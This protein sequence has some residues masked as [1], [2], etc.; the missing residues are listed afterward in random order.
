MSSGGPL[1]VVN[2]GGRWVDKKVFDGA[3]T[4]VCERAVIWS[5]ISQIDEQGNSRD[6]IHQRPPNLL[7]GPLQ[8]LCGQALFS[9]AA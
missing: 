9:L 4:Q 7:L 3:G 8:F 1:N 6:R 2:D 5:G